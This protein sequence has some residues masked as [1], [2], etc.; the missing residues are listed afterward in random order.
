MALDDSNQV[1]V[2]V[3]D[4]TLRIFHWALAVLVVVMFVSAKLENF[5]VHILAGKG[6]VMLM[7]ARI[8]WGFLGSSNARFS[9]LVFKPKEYFDYIAKLPQR[10]PGYSVEHSPIGSLAVIAIL[11]AVIVQATTGMFATN[12][13]GLVEGPFAYYVSYDFSRWASDVHVTHKKWLF[14]LVI[15]HLAANAFYYF[16][17]KDNLTKPMIT[18]TRP[19]PRNLAHTAP[20][21]ASPWRGA[22]IALITAAIMLWVF[23][24]YG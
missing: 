22:V 14:A 21:L 9:S 7:I 24:Q 15:L 12:V 10:T 20:T 4:I 19:I 6:I 3:W 2:N 18:G 16:Y 17:K 1:V 11:L 23:L 8:I 13:D 5:D